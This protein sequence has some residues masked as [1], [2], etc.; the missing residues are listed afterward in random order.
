MNNFSLF[1]SLL[2]KGCWYILS[3]IDNN[4]IRMRTHLVIY[5]F[6]WDKLFSSINIVFTQ[7]INQYVLLNTFTLI[8]LQTVLLISSISLSLEPWTIES[9]LSISI[10]FSSF[11][12]LYFFGCCECW[13][14]W[15]NVN[16]ACQR[17]CT[18]QITS[19]KTLKFLVCQWENLL[20]AIRMLVKNS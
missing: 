8:F 17:S 3:I 16:M 14:K 12:V 4:F 6:S 18:S 10:L 15:K 5:I 19:C 2:R 11:C 20:M 9:S 7:C 1:D 13:W